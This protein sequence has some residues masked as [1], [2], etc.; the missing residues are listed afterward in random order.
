MQLYIYLETI[1]LMLIVKHLKNEWSVIFFIM[2]AWL[3]FG[4]N[5]LLDYKYNS[6]GGVGLE[7]GGTL[8]NCDNFILVV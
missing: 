6:D 5:I 2:I 1:S 3:T 8:E 4:Y 7:G